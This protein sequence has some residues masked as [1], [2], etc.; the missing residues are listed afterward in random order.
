MF[1]WRSGDAARLAPAL[2]RWL[3]D[4]AVP[5]AMAAEF[6]WVRPGPVARF[7]EE[8]RPVEGEFV[9]SW[10]GIEGFYRGTDA[11]FLTSVLDLVRDIRRA[12]CD[13]TLR[14]GQSLWTLVVSRSRRHGLR[15]DQPYL[16]FQFRPGG[17]D[18]VGRVEGDERLSVPVIGL[19]PAVEAALRRLA[20]RPID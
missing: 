17:M 6:D 1:R 19:T 7:Y 14:A 20:A 10:D 13:R 4:R 3:C 2:R 9:T 15:D 11:P 12:G 8:G 16:A 5:S 18:V